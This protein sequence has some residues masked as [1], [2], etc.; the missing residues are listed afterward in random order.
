VIECVPVVKFDFAYVAT[1]EASVPEPSSVVPSQKLTE[2]VGVLADEETVAV[3]VT[4]VDTS[5]GLA[6]DAKAT[7]GAAWLTVS[8]PLPVADV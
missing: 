2:P 7:V 3:R 1:P 4:L 8:D 5:A 6:D